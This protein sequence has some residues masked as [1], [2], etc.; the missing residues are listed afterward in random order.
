[1]YSEKSNYSELA[2]MAIIDSSGVILWSTRNYGKLLL[3]VGSSIS[4]LLPNFVMDN[5]KNPLYVK[6]N[7][8]NYVADIYPWN[9][10]QA[11]TLVFKE[12]QSS[13]NLTENE[14]MKRLINSPYEGMV[15]VDENKV[16]RYVNDPF[17]NYNSIS[18]DEV[19]NQKLG[20][21]NLDL[22]R[23]FETKQFEP[24]TYVNTGKRKFIVSR[25]PVFRN[26]KFVGVFGHYIS[27]DPRD[28]ERKY[29]R[30]YYGRDYI[31]II[32]RLQTKDIMEN[33]AETIMELN[34]YKDEFNKINSVSSGIHN[35]IGISSVIKNL[36]EK[37]L[38]ICNSPSSVLITGESGTG[39]ELFAQAIHFQGDRSSKPF[40]KVNCAAIP[41]NLL[42]SE[43]FGYV[44]GAFTGARKGGKKGKFEL[45]NKGTIFLDEIGDMPMAMQAKLLRVLQ[46]R[47][48]ERLGSEQSVKI[49][50]RLI[51]A[52]NKDLL[53][54]VRQGDFREDLYYRVNVIHL[55]IP[56][57]RERKD[58]IPEIVKYIIIELNSTL[59]KNILTLSQEMKKIFAN[60]D[61]PGNVRELRNILEAA[62]NFSSGSE[63]DIN[64]L[65][66]FFR[67]QNIDKKHE[68]NEDLNSRLGNV[69][70]YTLISV[71]SECN[72]K[73][74][75]AA[76]KLNV[77][78]STF[79]RLMKKYNLE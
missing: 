37:I 69:E 40:I 68:D 53:S 73:H 60:Y 61:W 1:M 33:V 71:L 39:K 36:K 78:K 8:S 58:D 6:V 49:D 16:I 12:E 38:L 47:E 59:N 22:D 14:L 11:A 3:L 24:L 30:D 66:N 55:H 57:L 65:P 31:D 5:D 4:E 43:L 13:S 56:P 64:V 72:G 17:L 50:V 34:A 42:E 52:T 20:S 76:S 9:N 51:V 19:I 77:S 32:N 70:K 67:L 2:P 26:N 15:Y 41:E 54:L 21:F 18:R 7:G 27:I 63:I 79:Y 29:K 74:K 75:D 44:E 25:G 35:I 10:G 23:T 28:V 46:E 62:M 45:A 48:I